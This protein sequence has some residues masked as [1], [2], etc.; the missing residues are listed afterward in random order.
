MNCDVGPRREF[1]D[2]PRFDPHRISTRP[3]RFFEGSRRRTA[4]LSYSRCRRGRR[5]PAAAPAVTSCPKTSA[6]GCI[7]MPTATSKSSPAKLK[8]ART[9]A[10]RSPR[11]SPKNCACPSTPSPW[12]W[13]IPTLSP[14]TWAPSAA[15]PRPPWRPQL[16]NMAVAG[17]RTPGGDGRA[18]LEHRSLKIDRCRRKIATPDGSKSLTY[19]EL[20]RGEAL[21]KSVAG[22]P[23]SRPQPNGRSQA[24]RFPR[25]TAATL[26][27]ANISSLPTS[28]VPG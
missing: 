3:P 14:G 1:C 9:S 26:S 20:T 12:S 11:P 25:P 24:R 6:P 5:N 18:A 2:A 8:S 23:P 27:P 16:R 4:R 7:S 28:C 21:V 22:D 13:A 15:A 19:G 10:L 17:A